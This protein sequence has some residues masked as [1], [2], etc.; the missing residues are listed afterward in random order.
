MA[1]QEKFC[2]TCGHKLAEY[3]HSLSKILLRGMYKLSQIGGGPASVSED[4]QLTKSEYTNFAKLA[5][6]D[7]IE[8]SESQRGEKGGWWVITDTGWRFLRNEIKLPQSVRVFMKEVVRTEGPM[9]SIMDI[10]QGRW[11][12]RPEYAREAIPHQ[13]DPNEDLFDE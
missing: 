2:P 11:Y 9:T 10:T 5:Y 7:L 13:L 6:W 8:K 1:K 4:L 3:K 12:Y